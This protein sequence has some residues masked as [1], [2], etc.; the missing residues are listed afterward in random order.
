MG[1]RAWIANADA[2]F[3]V[4]KEGLR[5]QLCIRHG[6]NKNLL[7]W[8]GIISDKATVEQLNMGGVAT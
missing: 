1:F 6:V 3:L 8:S 4:V 7:E 5:A 2:S